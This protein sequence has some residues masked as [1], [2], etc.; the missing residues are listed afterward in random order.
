MEL[1][2]S[3][4]LTVN[5]VKVKVYNGDFFNK[6]ANSLAKEALKLQPIEISFHETGSILSPQH[7]KILL[8]IFQLEILS[9]ILIKR[10]LI[11][12]GQIKP[13]I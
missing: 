9:R 5:L 6:R 8:S 2:Q 3:K 11:S 1:V 7:G 13:E 10:Q 4:R 12:S